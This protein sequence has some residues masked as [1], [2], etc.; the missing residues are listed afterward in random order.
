MR[1]PKCN[2]AWECPPS[3]G[4][5]T[6]AHES[7]R[8]G[9]DRTAR[10]RNRAEERWAGLGKLGL[11]GLGLG[12]QKKNELGRGLLAKGQP[13]SGQRRRQGWGRRF[14]PLDAAT[15]AGKDAGDSSGRRWHSAV[16]DLGLTGV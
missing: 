6:D 5:T 1:A 15:T 7:G 13:G 4:R 2:A 14:S 9:L 12:L 10:K 16:V 8:I 11:D 3:R